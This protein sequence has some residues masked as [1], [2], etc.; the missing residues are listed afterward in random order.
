M[1]A[2]YDHSDRQLRLLAWVCYNSS[3]KRNAFELEAWDGRTD[4]R[5]PASLK[6]LD[7]GGRGIIDY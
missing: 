3:V 2:T 5:T 6:A 4:G 1:M 7:F